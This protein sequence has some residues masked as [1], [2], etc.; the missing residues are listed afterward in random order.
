MFTARFQLVYLVAMV[1][2][3]WG[4][5][6]LT[7]AGARRVAGAVC[8]VLVFTAISA[9]IDNIGI[10]M[11]WWRYPSYANPP[12]PPLALYLGQAFEFVGTIALIGWRVQRRFGA[13]GVAW[14]TAIACG[15][16]LVRDLSVA[17]LMPDVIRFGAMPGSVVADIA[18]WAIVVFVAL[19]VTRVVAGRADADA[20]RESE[21]AQAR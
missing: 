17:H 7:R 11:G 1:A 19:A 8:S 2:L 10:D 5:A 16:G 3:F 21:R 14:L 20:L 15:A 6:W 4:V 18:A 9:P 12:H 13:R